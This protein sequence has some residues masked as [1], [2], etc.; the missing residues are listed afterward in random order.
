MLL[1]SA[2]VD[3]LLPFDTPIEEMSDSREIVSQSEFLEQYA[4]G[5]KKLMSQTILTAWQKLNSPT[6]ELPNFV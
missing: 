4:A 3:N 1:Y 2:Y 6:Q 5:N